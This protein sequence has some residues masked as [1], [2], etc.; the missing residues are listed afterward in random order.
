LKGDPPFLFADAN[1]ARF[2][3]IIKGGMQKIVKDVSNTRC[4]PVADLPR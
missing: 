3:D 2:E 1:V 4:I